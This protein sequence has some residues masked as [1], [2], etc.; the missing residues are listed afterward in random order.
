MQKA[1]METFAQSKKR[2]GYQEQ[3]NCKR[4]KGT[5]TVAYLREKA[6]LDA[7]L[8]REI[9]RDNDCCC[10]FNQS[11]LTCE[12]PLTTV[13]TKRSGRSAY[14]IPKEVL[15]ELRGFNFS[16]C[17]ISDTFGVSRSTVMRRVQ[18]YELSDL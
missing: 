12:L 10:E 4:S 13:D 8:K 2:K 16:W 3:K 5:E 15:V 11:A 7:S 14:H 17:K 6:K 1:S 18:E 9:I